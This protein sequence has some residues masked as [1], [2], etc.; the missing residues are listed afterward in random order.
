MKVIQDTPEILQIR[1]RPHFLSL[2]GLKGLLGLGTFIGT[3]ILIIVLIREQHPVWGWLI[4]L[5][6]LLFGV[7]I[8]LIWIKMWFAPEVCT[9]D[10]QRRIVTLK[11]NMLPKPGT[12]EHTF[13]DIVA[14]QVVPEAV[15]Y[16]GYM[17]YVKWR[18]QQVRKQAP[19]SVRY[20]ARNAAMLMNDDYNKDRYYVRLAVKPGV[21]P[22][23]A[24][25]SSTDRAALE[26]LADRLRSVL[27]KQETG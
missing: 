1:N 6:F 15:G 17:E 7:W 10:Q 2:S 26:A 19:A 5:C 9:F 27:G 3:G 12:M 22:Y 24:S 20:M 23:L 13:D 11:L 16:A 25:H 18:Y 21:Y 8:L 14:V 4:G